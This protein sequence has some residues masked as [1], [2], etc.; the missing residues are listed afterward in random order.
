MSLRSRAKTYG[1]HATKKTKRQRN[2]DTLAFRLNVEEALNTH[3]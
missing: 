2:E 1:L 3:E